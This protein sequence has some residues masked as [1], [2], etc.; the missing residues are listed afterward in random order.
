[1]NDLKHETIHKSIVVTCASIFLMWATYFLLRS[2]FPRI[3]IDNDYYLLSLF[4]SAL[5]FI[6]IIISFVLDKDKIRKMKY[7]KL[8]TH[9]YFASVISLSIL[10]TLVE[11]RYL[12]QDFIGI[13]MLC[14]LLY[15]VIHFINYFY[16]LIIFQNVEI[17]LEQCD[18][19]LNENLMIRNNKVQYLFV[20]YL[21]I[22]LLLTTAIILDFMFM[23][24]VNELL[25]IGLLI[26]AVSSIFISLEEK[27]KEH[28]LFAI[29]STY[30]AVILLLIV[31]FVQGSDTDFFTINFISIYLI[32]TIAI[33]FALSWIAILFFAGDEKSLKNVRL[34]LLNIFMPM[35]VLFYN[36]RLQNSVYRFNFVFEGIEVLYYLIYLVLIVT[37]IIKIVKLVKRR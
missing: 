34:L 22:I 24:D 20:F 23:Y 31:G 37:Q 9:Y 36:P 35:S 28:T 11:D 21:S 1:M 33:S 2:I 14:V 17:E 10:F 15:F 32:L 25:F 27:S 3:E 26:V 7:L 30:H 6:P 18:L 4:A 29:S 12:L 19:Q 8:N 16:I 13:L 5:L